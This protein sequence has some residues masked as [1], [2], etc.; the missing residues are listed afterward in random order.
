MNCV[1]IFAPTKRFGEEADRVAL[2]RLK[3]HV[4]LFILN[5]VSARSI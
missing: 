4:L 5:L 3:S 2:C 1:E